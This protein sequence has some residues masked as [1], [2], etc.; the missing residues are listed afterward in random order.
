MKIFLRV[1]WHLVTIGGK[2][3]SSSFTKRRTTR[4]IKNVVLTNLTTSTCTLLHQSSTHQSLWKCREWTPCYN[5]RSLRDG[6]SMHGHF[7][8]NKSQ[9]MRATIFSTCVCG[10]SVWF[11]GGL[12]WAIDGVRSTLLYYYYYAV[13]AAVTSSLTTFLLISVCGVRQGWNEPSS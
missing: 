2:R 9:N 6:F 4:K 5:R 12:I 13:V 7:C 3:S 8:C 1:V 10:G 11:N